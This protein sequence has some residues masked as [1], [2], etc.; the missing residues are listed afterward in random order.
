MG[1]LRDQLL[2]AGLVDKKKIKEAAH[3]ERIKRKTGSFRQL[4][5][6][7]TLKDAEWTEKQNLQKIEQ[8]KL[9]GEQ[10]LKQQNEQPEQQVNTIIKETR[11]GQNW[12]GNRRFYFSTPENR[13]TY[14]NVSDTIGAKLERGET[15]SP[16]SGGYFIISATGARRIDKLAPECLRFFN[17]PKTASA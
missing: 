14:L 6:E 17:V 7:K 16:A 10:K 12:A 13:I 3:E 9:A 4:E 8:Q 1:S 11:I 15:S 2:K 5:H